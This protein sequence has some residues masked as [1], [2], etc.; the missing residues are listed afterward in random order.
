MPEKISYYG[1]LRLND[2]MK[3]TQYGTTVKV[4]SGK[5]GQVLLHSVSNGNES[6]NYYWGIEI[7][8][9]HTEM[10]VDQYKKYVTVQIVCYTNEDNFYKRKNG[11]FFEERQE[12]SD[13]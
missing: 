9:I 7:N 4:L 6:H 13:A 3:N 5:T 2:L 12:E 11:A 8:G 10:K 1:G